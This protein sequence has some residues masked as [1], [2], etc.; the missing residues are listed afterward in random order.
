MVDC[1]GDEDEKCS[2]TNKA[3]LSVVRPSI[4]DEALLK[5]EALISQ[6]EPTTR[7]KCQVIRGGGQ[8]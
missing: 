8:R 5:I 7:G 2:F 6:I 1:D 4:G 3:P